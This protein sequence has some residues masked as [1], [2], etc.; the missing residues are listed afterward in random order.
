MVKLDFPFVERLCFECGK[1]FIPAP[2]H[3]FKEL[4][5]GKTY[6]FCG[7]NCKCRFEKKNPKPIF[8]RLK[9]E[10]ECEEGD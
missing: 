1:S 4:R 7:Y 8:G 5:K 2:E 3:I 9:Y 6:W 10:S